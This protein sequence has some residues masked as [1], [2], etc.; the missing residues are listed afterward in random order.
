MTFHHCVGLNPDPDVA[1]TKRMGGCSGCRF[2][3]EW[4][5]GKW[6]DATFPPL[7]VEEKWKAPLYR[8]YKQR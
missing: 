4:I 8:R 2:T 7:G 6:S 1:K 5:S 3:A